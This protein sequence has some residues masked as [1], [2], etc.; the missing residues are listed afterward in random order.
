MST[1]H[2]YIPIVGE[3]VIEDLT[4]LAKRLKGKSIQNIN[5]TA[6]GGGVAEI[7]NR[8]IP[9]LK[10]MDIDVY[11]N[12]IKGGDKFF[13][14]TKKIH[15]TLHGKLD[16]ISREDWR[17]YDETI[18]HNLT[19]INLDRDIIFIHDPQPLGLIKNKKNNN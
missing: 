13:E 7:L 16:I 15:N 9:I 5:S 10:E 17:V 1:L 4:L 19:D 12:V 8:M 2:D 11:W 3:S 18:E 6:V 14:V